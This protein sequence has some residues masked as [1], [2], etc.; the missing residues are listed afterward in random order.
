MPTQ[1]TITSL[2]LNGFEAMVGMF[3]N[4]RTIVTKIQYEYKV[5]QTSNNYHDGEWRE[6]CVS[7][8]IYNIYSGDEL[9]AE[10]QRGPGLI[11][12]YESTKEKENANTEK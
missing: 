2:M 9:L 10:V 4:D 8:D 5:I 1:K 11:L 7:A 12:K 6:D 3:W